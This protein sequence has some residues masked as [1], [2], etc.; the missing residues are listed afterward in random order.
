MEVK[1]KLN[2]ILGGIMPTKAHSLDAGFD[3]YTPHSFTVYAHDNAVID[4]GVHFAIPAGH[5]GFL[6][7]KSGLN[8]NHD[9]TAEGVVDAG[10]TGTVRVKL[11]NNGN[12]DYEFRAGDKVTQMVILPIPEVELVEVD[13]LEETERGTAGFGST[14]R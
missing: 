2:Q 12:K 3:I 10:Y 1:V 6:K 14:G 13:T 4:T 7:S 9:L 8:M 11:Y 5:V